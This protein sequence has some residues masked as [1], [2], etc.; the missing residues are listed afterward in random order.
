MN[1]QTGI[2]WLILTVFLEARNQPIAGQK[3]VAKLILNRAKSKNWPLSNIVFAKKQFSCYN[4]G[5]L[6][7]FTKVAPEMQYIAQVTENVNAAI[8]EWLA[9]DNL[10][11]ATHYFNPDEVAG[12]WPATWDRSKMT[13]LFKVGNHIFLKEG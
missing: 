13:V 11:G 12:G 8:D 7:A 1:I 9:G 3:D 6:K 5:L 4:D 2:F 10:K